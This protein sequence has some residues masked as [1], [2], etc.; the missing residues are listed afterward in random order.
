M[1]CICALA[2]LT[3]AAAPAEAAKTTEKA[4][5][6]KANASPKTKT[7][8]QNAL[9]KITGKCTQDGPDVLLTTK[10]A[11][12]TFLRTEADQFGF[13]PG[14][15]VSDDPGLTIF[16]AEDGD[17]VAE[18][19]LYDGQGHVTLIDSL[20]AAEGFKR[21]C[22][23]AG[24]V[25]SLKGKDNLRRN[26]EAPN[27]A[28]LPD[29]GPLHMLYECTNPGTNVWGNTDG[30]KPDFAGSWSFDADSVIERAWYPLGS[31]SSQTLLGPRVSTTGDLIV[32]QPNGAV[33]H[34]RAGLFLDDADSCE[35]RG[36]LRTL[37]KGNDRAF[38][39]SSP[40]PKRKLIFDA[41]GLRLYATCKPGQMK[42]FAA[43]DVKNSILH[44]SVI[45]DETG[46][47][48][49]DNDFDNSPKRPKYLLLFE[50][51]HRSGQIVYAT[52]NGH[53][54]SLNWS[55]IENAAAF[56]PCLFAGAARSA[57]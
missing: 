34:L 53:V 35:L 32:M 47:T 51:I 25:T 52:P 7:L 38:F 18:T 20:T 49:D 14:V 24:I 56:K 1:F 19:V 31:S 50:G 36:N 10:T 29:A 40:R 21:K 4:I 39:G 44:A 28:A 11:N 41:N 33:S 37:R 17:S 22:A 55:A 57:S 27:S 13:G 2:A 15:G 6:Y 5:V 30:G 12:T 26:P 23:W 45:G 16:L 54:T 9:F 3:C 48:V 8:L 43:T 42:I 46:I